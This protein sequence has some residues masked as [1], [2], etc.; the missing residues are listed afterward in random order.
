MKTIIILRVLVILFLVASLLLIIGL[1]RSDDNDL[2]RKIDSLGKPYDSSIFT[3]YDNNIYA[4]VPSNGEY[5]LNNVDVATFKVFDDTKGYRAQKTAYDK[6]HMYAGNRIVPN[7]DPAKTI[8]LGEGYYSDGK[9]TYYLGS[10]SIRNDDLNVFVEVLQM[11]L[12]GLNITDKPQT[13]LYPIQELPVSKQAYHPILNNSVATDGQAVFYAG[14]SLLEANPLTLR[15]LS[16][17][18][19]DGDERPSYDY[20]ADDKNVYYKNSLLPLKSNTEIYSFEITSNTIE[21][22]LYDPQTG[23]VLMHDIAFANSNAPYQLITPFGAHVYHALL[24]SENGIYYYDREDESVKRAGDNPFK[25]SNFQPL[26]EFV[27]TDGKSTLFLQAEQNW[28]SRNSGRTR[29]QHTY[30][31]QIKDI[32]SSLWKKVGLLTSDF[33]SVWENADKLYYFDNLGRGQ[34]IANSVYLIDNQQ[35]VETLLNKDLR[36]ATVKDLIDSDRLVAVEGTSIITASSKYGSDF[37][38]IWLIIFA[39]AI[40][41][42]LAL[43]QKRFNILKSPFIIKDHKLQMISLFPK[44]FDLSEIRQVVFLMHHNA[45]AGY[46]AKMQIQLKDGHHSKYYLFSKTLR[47]DSELEM[48]EF[49]MEQQQ[50]LRGHDIDS[51]F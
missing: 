19:D 12:Y 28:S 49:I 26:S 17:V 11:M 8:S 10:N 46:S 36:S 24:S 5:Q 23:K 3:L 21:S 40:I 44:S 22:Y 18:Y 31:K 33:G 38:L 4:S 35:T 14:M 15:Q 41:P 9:S 1:I 51:Q 47:K 37:N 25:G 43:L 42:V 16:Q 48:S 50:L 2:S 6:N 30:I 34:S 32:D 39:I 27:F 45:R 13:Y 29:S 7:L 20:F